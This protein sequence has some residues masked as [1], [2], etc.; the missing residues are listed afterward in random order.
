MFEKVKKYFASKIP[1]SVLL[2]TDHYGFRLPRNVKTK[3]VLPRNPTVKQLRNFSREPIVR[4]AI[5]LVQDALAMQDYRIEVIGGRGKCTKQI[6]ALKNIIENPNVIDSRQSFVK[7]LV[8]DALVLDAMVVEVA[9]ST[10]SKH[11]LYLYPVD[12][13]TIR[14]LTPYAYDDPKAPRYCQQQESGMK[15]FTAKDIA[16]LQREYFTYQPYGLSPVMVAYK[17]I[18]YYLSA[19][20]QSNSKATNGTADYLIGLKDISNDER[21]RFVQYFNEE[22]EGTGKIPILNGTEIET[23][24]IRSGLN[25]L[26]Y[27]N[28][29][30][31]LTTIVGLAFGLP[32]EKLGLM[33]ANDRST[34]QDQENAVVQE[35]IKPYAS[36]YEDLINNYVINALGWGGLLRFRLLY[37]ESEQQKTAK[38]KRLVD[39]YYRGVITENEFRSMMGY[40]HS[41]SKY[42]DVTSPEKT[43]LINVDNGVAGGFNGVGDVKDTS[44]DREK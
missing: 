16:Y 36:M 37:E 44:K 29:Q 43:T 25:E 17:Y 24:Q 38:S 30:D 28:W 9:K 18:D 21:E 11:P 41:D 35:L 8:D 31:K 22:I 34:G 14:H 39:E 27:L 20:E 5:S 15:Y 10:D 7:R 33:I 40:E 1:S 13:S 42:A 2:P 19:V 32:P 6:V 23:K 4:R 3:S 26:S 12:G